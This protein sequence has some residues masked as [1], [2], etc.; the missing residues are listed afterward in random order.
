MHRRRPLAS[1]RKALG[2]MSESQRP[3]TP[4]EVTCPRC[5]EPLTQRRTGRP[6]VWCSQACRRAAYEERR[7]AAQ[8]AIA[9]EIVERI[10]TREHTVAEC[11]NRAI[12]SPAGCRRVILELT[13]RA[14]DGSL[15]S[16]PKWE[17]TQVALAALIR[18]LEPASKHGY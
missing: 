16:D 5:G 6:P 10:E 13:E 15:R 7:A 12:A 1:V 11:V 8:G 2:G 18:S 14:R 9:V 3:V 4:A 17:S